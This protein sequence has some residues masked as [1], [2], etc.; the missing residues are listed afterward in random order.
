MTE[1][2]GGELR[3]AYE[4]I[5]ADEL[6]RARDILSAYLVDHPND[7]DGWWLYAHAVS[8]ASQGLKA[9]ET[10]VK[11]DPKYPGAQALIDEAT[12]FDIEPAPSEPARP[13][14]SLASDQPKSRS[15]EQPAAQARSSGGRFPVWLVAVVAL[16]IIVA[17]LALLLPRIVGQNGQS[18]TAVAEATETPGSAG[19]SSTET[20]TPQ[21]VETNTDTPAT[22]TPSATPETATDAPTESLP[23]PLA[24]FQP[25]RQARLRLNRRLYRPRNQ[26]VPRLLL[27][28]LL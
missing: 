6:A 5:Q 4:A 22:D 24:K 3:A 16:L 11:L 2:S 20:V 27:R 21:V 26:A 8:D 28:R 14:R 17:A 15:V 9:L 12:T 19:V 13:V 18:P 23:R 25:K 10:V 1:A 7:P